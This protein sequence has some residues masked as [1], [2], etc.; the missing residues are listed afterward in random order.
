[1]TFF[2]F[3]GDGCI[4]TCTV[5]FVGVLAFSFSAQKDLGWSVVDSCFWD[6]SFTRVTS[7][8]DDGMMGVD[9]IPIPTSLPLLLC[10]LTSSELY[11]PLWCDFVLGSSVHYYVAT[12]RS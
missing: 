4:G 3:G 2:V 5:L 11:S 1:M 10:S 6:H 12:E 7:N 8:H 9:Y